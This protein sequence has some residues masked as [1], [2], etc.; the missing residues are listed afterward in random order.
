MVK[1]SYKAII[2]IIIIIIVMVVAMMQT[3]CFNGLL[4]DDP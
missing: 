4:R 3:K 2:T 1:A